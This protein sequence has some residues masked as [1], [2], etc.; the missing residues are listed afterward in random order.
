MSKTKRK[1]SAAQRDKF[2][3]AIAKELKK[4]GILSKQT[5]L[6]GG[7]FISRDVLKKVKA[8]TDLARLNYGTVK[9][10]K[11]VAKAAKERGY[12]VVQGNRIV[13][14]KTTQFRN[15]LKTGV[16][17][18][19]KPVKGGYMEEVILPHTVYDIPSLMGQ[20]EEGIDTL[21]LPNEQF[22]FK[23]RGNE[24]YRSFMNSKQLYEY[25]QHYKGFNSQTVSQKPEDMQEDFDAI[26]IF[27]LHPNA[28]NENLPTIR[29][30]KERAAQRRAEK[31]K[32]GLWVTR[33]KK[34]KSLQE[35]C[36][37]G[38]KLRLMHTT[39][40]GRKFTRALKI[41]LKRTLLNM[42]LT[43]KKNANA[44]ASHRKGLKMIDSV[45]AHH[46]QEIR[47]KLSSIEL[48]LPSAELRRIE[49]EEITERLSK[50]A[51]EV[52]SILHILKV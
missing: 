10:N 2:N 7:Q 15:R 12:T 46:I 18:G 43:Q 22:A 47:R 39:R 17:T 28:V 3:I 11:E 31:I 41:A 8:Y 32:Q 30:R 20:L 25:L 9:V 23:Y 16:V 29:E 6:H 26:T 42:R 44:N 19:V 48:E 36:K 45:C 49:A 40:S 52:R 51:S 50:A 4:S 24:S 21:K 34:T 37:I 5:K 33:K 27:R 38:H 35:E 13:G 1:P 14:P